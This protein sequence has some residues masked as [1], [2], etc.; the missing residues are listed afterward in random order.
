MFDKFSNKQDER[1][2]ESFV[3]IVKKIS[4]NQNRLKNDINTLSSWIISWRTFY[5]KADKIPQRT[6]MN[7]SPDTHLQKEE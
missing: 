3:G 5:L 4:T 2:S 1:F 6:L 7:E